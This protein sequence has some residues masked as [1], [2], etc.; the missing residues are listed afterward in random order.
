MYATIRRFVSARR[1]GVKMTAHA[2]EGMGGQDDRPYTPHH[3][4]S[5]LSMP[6]PI[7]AHVGGQDDPPSPRRGSYADHRLQFPEVG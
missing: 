2:A 3:C 4:G 7:T 1:W 6:G 5:T